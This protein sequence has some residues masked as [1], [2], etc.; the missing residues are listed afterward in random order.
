MDYFDIL[1]LRNTGDS[2]GELVVVVLELDDMEDT[3]YKVDVVGGDDDIVGDDKED[4]V[5]DVS[6]VV[7]DTDSEEEISAVVCRDSSLLCHH[8]KIGTS[9]NLALITSCV[10]G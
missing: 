9:Y 7:D 3:E 2:M 4:S 1:G 6:A 5:V 8:L 10:W